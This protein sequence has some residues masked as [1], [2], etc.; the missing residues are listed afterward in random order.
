[1]GERRLPA[2]LGTMGIHYLRP[3]LLGITSVDPRV[4]GSGMHTDFSMPAMLLNELQADGSLVLVGVENLVFEAAWKNAGHAEPS[5]LLGLTSGHMADDPATP[6]D[7]AHRFQP[8]YDQH[9]WLRENPLGNLI[10]TRPQPACGEGPYP[11]SPRGA[12]DRAPRIYCGGAS[13]RGYSNS[14]RAAFRWRWPGSQR[15]DAT[16]IGVGF[17]CRVAP[18]G[19]FRIVLSSAPWRRFLGAVAAS[20]RIAVTFSRP[21]DHRGIQITS[22]A[23]H[24]VA[25]QPGDAELAR[26]QSG[27]FADDLVDVG[28]PAPYA[29]IYSAFDPARPHRGRVT[30]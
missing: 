7:E 28:Y 4:D 11:L 10:P 8:H 12:R 19:T 23:S 27:I 2:D 1:M 3:D 30:A 22:S 29:V 13:C 5:S 26:N 21:N 24:I 18:D 6:G 25:A 15:T 16:A 20:G 17:G 9:V 14:V